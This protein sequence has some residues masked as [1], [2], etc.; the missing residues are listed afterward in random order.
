MVGLA[1]RQKRRIDADLVQAG[2]QQESADTTTSARFSFV[3]LEMIG[4]PQH[5][6]HAPAWTFHQAEQVGVLDCHIEIARLRRRPRNRPP[7]HALMLDRRVAI[8]IDRDVVSA[9]RQLPREADHRGFGPAERFALQR[10]PVVMP[11][12]IREDDGGH[13]LNG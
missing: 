12:G 13:G 2:E 7:L 6:D 9:P 3:V 8:G 10:S 5:P 11:R 4:L 1:A